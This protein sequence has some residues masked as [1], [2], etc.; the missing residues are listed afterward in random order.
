MQRDNIIKNFF[1]RTEIV[2]F[3]FYTNPLANP[4]V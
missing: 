4:I 3:I 1:N 2:R